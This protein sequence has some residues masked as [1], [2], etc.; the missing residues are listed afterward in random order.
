MNG[1][2]IM[3][4]NPESQLN[5]VSIDNTLGNALDDA[6]DDTFLDKGIAAAI[7]YSSPLMP[8]P[9]SLKLRLMEHLGLP[10]PLVD[11]TVDLTVDTPLKALLDWSLVDLIAAA[12]TIKKWTPLTSPEEATYAPWKIDKPNRQMAYFVRAPR[13]GALPTHH[14]ATREVVLVLEGDFTVEGSCYRAGDRLCSAADTIHQPT[15]TGCLVLI[16][17]SLDDR[18]TENVKT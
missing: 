4:L 17:S 3:K 7:A 10:L 6:L 8:L 13:A 15:T 1:L 9:D 12:S 5:P 11:L 2:D 16:L 14:H 18:P